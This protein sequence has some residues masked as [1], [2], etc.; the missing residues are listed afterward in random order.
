MA[1]LSEIVQFLDNYL[2]N[3]SIKDDSF[4]GL[5]FEGKEE[6]NKVL[7]AVDTGIETFKKAVEL[8]ADMV[9]VH[10]GHFWEK[11]N[12]CIKG[13]A[14]ERFDILFE[15]QISLYASH[16]PLDRHREVGNNAQLLELL[17]AKITED[18]AEFEGISISYAGIVKGT[19][20]E[21]IKELI[22][23]KLNT[24]CYA[25]EFGNKRVEKIAVCSGGGG[26]KV[27]N[28]A[29]EL[30]PDL[31]ITGEQTELYHLAKDAGINV[32]FAGHHATETLGVKA[33]SKVVSENFNVKSEF[34]DIP[35]GL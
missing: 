25:L 4:N 17:D 6:V 8:E 29:I 35:T 13:F 10:H 31:Y 33:L 1:K 23:K 5:Q 15:N 22:E 16:L 2:E 28:Q 18:F 14:K 9:I 32:I 19:T 20:V 34:V 7:F 24:T 26:L 21:N 11:L 12:P 3:A 27:F 30:K